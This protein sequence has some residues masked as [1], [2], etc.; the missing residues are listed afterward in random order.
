[1]AFTVAIY[2][3]A[4]FASGTFAIAL[5]CFCFTTA[6]V[7][8]M[9]VSATVRAAKASSS[10]NWDY[11]GHRW[12]W[13][14]NGRRNYYSRFCDSNYR[15]CYCYGR[16]NNNSRRRNDVAWDVICLNIGIIGLLRRGVWRVWV[17][18]PRKR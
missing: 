15:F 9:M 5:G 1:L 16:G 3:Y 18:A 14:Q 6:Q 12:R 4:A 10:T 13:G 8:V 11:K 17:A 2:F 7:M